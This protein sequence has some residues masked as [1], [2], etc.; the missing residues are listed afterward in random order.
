MASKQ[1]PV[2][3]SAANSAHIASEV[4]PNTKQLRPVSGFAPRGTQEALEAFGRRNREPLFSDIAPAGRALQVPHTP[5]PAPNVQLLTDVAAGSS[6]APAHRQSARKRRPWFVFAVIS[7]AVALGAMLGYALRSVD[8]L[9]REAVSWPG[10]VEPQ[11]PEEEEVVPAVVPSVPATAVAPAPIR[12][13]VVETPDEPVAQDVEPE[14]AA[15][16]EAKRAPRR[17]VPHPVEAAPVLK[18]PAPQT[19]TP[20]PRPL[21]PAPPAQ[22]QNSLPPREAVIAGFEDVRRR[23]AACAGERN[24]VAEVHATIA[25]SSG[26][27]THALIRGDFQGTPEG[28]CMARA[29]RAA[30][31]P[32]FS[33]ANMKVEYPFAL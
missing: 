13:H 2:S 9:R 30:T 32:Q 27:V 11:V 28:S 3:G 10:H 19:D 15:A 25:G 33:R 12:E 22:A 31:F 14:V 16:D 23:L 4:A 17:K 18:V 21:P 1:D 8:S 6:A 26:R 20:E 24:G 29:V 5:P 7:S